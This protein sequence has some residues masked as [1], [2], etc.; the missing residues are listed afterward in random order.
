M[1]CYTVGSPLSP[2]S[3]TSRTVNATVASPIGEFG[4]KVGSRIHKRL[5]Y[6]YRN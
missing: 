1:T 2:N 3:T 6:L 5:V 4:I